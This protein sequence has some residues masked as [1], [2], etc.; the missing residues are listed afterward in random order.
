MDKRS[1]DIMP[2]YLADRADSLKKNWHRLMCWVFAL[3]HNESLSMSVGYS[4]L[5]LLT[6]ISGFCWIFP[7]I[8]TLDQFNGKNW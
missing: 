4:L 3:L 7:Q 1:H 6:A 2:S 8:Y 5:L